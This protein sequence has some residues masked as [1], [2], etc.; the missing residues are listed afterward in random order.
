MSMRTERKALAGAAALALLLG[1]GAAVATAPPVQQSSAQQTPP[2]RSELTADFLLSAAVLA[3]P[4]ATA[5][6]APVFPLAPSAEPKHRFEGSLELVVEPGAARLR[7]LN[8]RFG[9]LEDPALQIGRLPPFSFAFV[10]DGSQL[11]PA[12]RGPQRSPHPHW[13]FILEPG[14]VW[15]E[16]GDGGWSRAALPFALQ[17]RN[18]NCTHNGLLTFLFHAD[19]ST[20]RAAFQIGSETCQYLQ[21]DLWGTAAAHYSPASVGGAGQLIADHRRERAARLPVRPLSALATDYPGTDVGEFDWFPSEEVSAVGFAIDGVHYRGGCATR[22]GP[23]PFCEVLDL[24]SYSLAK[25]IFAGLAWLALEREAPGIGRVTVPSLVPECGDSRWAGVTLQHLLDMS[26]GNYA[27]L[28]ANAAEFAS[29]ETPFMAGDTHAAKIGMACSLFRRRAEPGTTFAYHTSDTYIAGTLMNAWLAR[30]AA[31]NDATARDIHRDVLVAELMRPLGLSPLTHASKR[32]YDSVAQPFTGWGLTLHADDIVRLGLFLL[33]GEGAVDGRQ[34]LEPAGLAAALQRDP[35]D[36][37]LPA[38][39]D[40]LRYNNGFWGYRTD[41][42]GAC[43]ESIWIPFMSGYG[44]IS[45]ALLP[46]GSLY[47]VFS[48]HGRFEWLRAAAAAHR[49]RN[50]CE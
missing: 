1:A 9:Y 27:S 42:G 23:Y 5:A 40:S 39:S 38:G 15:D 16:P 29:Y 36:R 8:D 49:I 44:G 25:S 19:G 12:R 26:T 32:T 28:D 18:A 13:E 4:V 20:S 7:G 35:A 11:V 48:D 31:T 41:L 21:F 6:F 24:P 43:Q 50:L 30:Q 33:Q 10:Q 2:A 46:N 34:V 17:E 22:H 3:E 45:V 14:S 47:Y 37:G